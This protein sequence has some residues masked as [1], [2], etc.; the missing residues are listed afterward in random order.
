MVL[1]EGAASGGQGGTKSETEASQ[2]VFFRT[3]G[4]IG[5]NAV[6]RTGDEVA[7]Y[8]ESCYPVAGPVRLYREEPIALAFTENFNIVLPEVPYESAPN[9]DDP[10]G[11][12]H[13]VAW[14]LAVD[15]LGGGSDGEHLSATSDDW[16][17][18]HRKTQVGLIASVIP[19]AGAKLVSEVVREATTLDP[20]KIRFE[21]MVAS[22]AGCGASGTAY[23]KSQVLFHDPVAAAGAAPLWPADSVL[24]ANLRVKGGPITERTRFADGDET[25]FDALTES[26]AGA[27]TWAVLDGALACLQAA[28]TTRYY[29]VFGD[30]EWNH[31]Q[32]HATVDPSG[33][34]AGVALAVEGTSQV[35]QALLVIVDEAAATLALVAVSAGAA[36]V[37][38]SVALPATAAA[39]Y[40]LEVVAFDDVVRAAVGEAVVESEREEFRDGKLA[41]VAQGEASFTK[42]IVEPV[43]AYRFEARTSRFQSFE[44]HVESFGGEASSIPASAAGAGAASE[45]PAAM[46]AKTRTGIADAMKPVADRESRQRLFDAWTLGLA[47]PLRTRCRRLEISAIEAAAGAELLLIES[48]EPLPFSRDVKLDLSRRVL[49][50]ALQVAAGTFEEMRSALHFSGDRMVGPVVTGEAEAVLARSRWAVRATVVD[51][52][53]QFEIYDIQPPGGQRRGRRIE[54]KRSAVIKADAID[55]PEARRWRGVL[56]TLSPGFVV[57]L[58]ENGAAVRKPFSVVVS[59]ETVPIAILTD[60][61]ESRAIMIPLSSDGTQLS[62][63]TR[64]RYRLDFS[65]DRKRYRSKT[66]D[67]HSNYQGQATLTI[68][69]P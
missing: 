47:L 49:H 31:V 6:K 68:D 23:H 65:L 10:L 26:G 40:G 14:V 67:Q 29:A 27:G 33:G 13:L 43:D 60:G 58:D 41:L 61:D 62:T 20:F 35:G 7:P 25:A 69:L 9:P 30:K 66:I 37:L 42:L 39:P 51:G 32:I 18:A 21:A 53:G 54:G 36:K 64:G 59:W 52:E 12:A 1:S 8:V 50:H 15:K 3:K 55:G 17:D 4:M 16:L 5:L 45:T 44:D 63:L 34:K 38:E 22:A 46:F 56:G 28:G 11:Q 19:I 57:L 48:P 24:R 2:T